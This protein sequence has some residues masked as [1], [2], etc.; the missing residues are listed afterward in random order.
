MCASKTRN[1]THYEHCVLQW[2]YIPQQPGG[3]LFS[4]Y[5]LLH[6]RA[7]LSYVT[8]T[9]R[10]VCK[11]RYI[12]VIYLSIKFL[13]RIFFVIRFVMVP[14]LFLLLFELLLR[15]N[16]VTSHHLALLLFERQ[17]P[18]SVVV[19]TRLILFPESNNKS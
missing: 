6:S 3:K 17:Q 10:T 14:Y 13:L 12:A 1:Y 11:R 8:N 5:F 18:M 2:I 16:I 4:F 7:Y 9:Q 15:H 19:V